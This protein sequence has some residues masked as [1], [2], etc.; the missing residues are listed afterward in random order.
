M[1]NHINA[2]SL[3]LREGLDRLSSL[4]NLTQGGAQLFQKILSVEWG[5][6]WRLWWPSFGSRQGQ[7]REEATGDL[8]DLFFLIKISLESFYTICESESLLTNF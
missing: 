7:V 6:R 1:Q 3:S 5:P 4:Q 2:E 8:Q